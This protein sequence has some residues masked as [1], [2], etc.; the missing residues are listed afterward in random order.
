[1]VSK[2]FFIAGLTQEHKCGRPLGF[3]IDEKTNTLYVADAYYGIWKVDLKT[4]KKQL[5]VS[6][7]VPIEGKQP[8]LFN[9]IVLAE[10]G[11]VYWT[12]SSSDFHLKDGAI[13]ILTDPSG[14]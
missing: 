12:D 9:S 5:L 11:D 10:N 6:P 4:D 1:M 8:K 3:Q 2:F 7:Q 13:S 14:R